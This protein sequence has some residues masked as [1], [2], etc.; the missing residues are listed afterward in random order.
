MFSN[1]HHIVWLLT[2][3]KTD[4]NYTNDT[5]FY[6]KTSTEANKN[7]GAIFSKKEK[8]DQKHVWLTVIG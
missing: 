8:W 5:N 4:T 3:I 7:I 6:V 1:R 2:F